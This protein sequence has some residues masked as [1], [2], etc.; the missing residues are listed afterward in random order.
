[1]V[2][3]LTGADLEGLK[4]YWFTY[5][6]VAQARALISRT[7]Y[8]GEDGF[9]I[10]VPPNTADH[11]WQALLE[12]GRGAQV[13]AC[14]LGARDTLRL[15]A[16]MRLY[17]NDIDETT[18]PVESGL[19]WIVG[20]NKDG[21][22]GAERLRT[23]KAA[24]PGRL[25]VGLEVLDRGIARQGYA[26]LKDGQPVGV[27]TSGTQTPYLKKAVAMAYVPAALAEPGTGLDVDIRGRAVKA[28]VVALPF[29][30]RTR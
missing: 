21:F 20:W 5:G 23:Q 29:Y 14:G 6:E 15:E 22:I 8:T 1:V 24:G 13:L 2:Q 27:V 10:F 4:T 11:V 16:S 26:V 9:E 17:G 3:P 7:G 25:L 28:T 12:S 19:G 30:T 18:T